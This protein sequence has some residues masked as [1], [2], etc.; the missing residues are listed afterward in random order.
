MLIYCI[1]L[2]EEGLCVDVDIFFF[3]QAEDGIRDLVRSR[4]LG[5]VYKRQAYNRLVHA[6]TTARTAE[7]PATNQKSLSSIS[8]R[9]PTSGS[10]LYLGF[11]FARRLIRI[12]CAG[13]ARP[14]VD[15]RTRAA[16]VQRLAA[17]IPHRQRKGDGH[18]ST[19]SRHSPRST[20]VWP[21]ALKAAC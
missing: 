3:F 19:T 5:D 18:V 2:I 8:L 17:A 16:R 11:V 20:S 10:R 13:P 6:R 12:S 9:W 21:L 7:V 15:T 14:P 1:Y 4:G